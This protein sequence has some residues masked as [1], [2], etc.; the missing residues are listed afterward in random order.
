MY[1]GARA[2]IARWLERHAASGARPREARLGRHPDV[3]AG[4]GTTRRAGAEGSSAG[5]RRRD[6]GVP[7]R[8]ALFD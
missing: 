6:A 2:S 1:A 7:N 3:D 5:A 8:L 4:R